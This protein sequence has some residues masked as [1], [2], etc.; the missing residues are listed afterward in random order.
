MRVDT[1][2]QLLNLANVHPGGRYIVVDDTAG[3]VVGAVLERLGGEPNSIYSAIVT[4]ITS[5]QRSN[6]NHRRYR[7]STKLSCYDLHEL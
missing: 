2:G 6:T 5:R 7:V 3:L 4:K 1:L